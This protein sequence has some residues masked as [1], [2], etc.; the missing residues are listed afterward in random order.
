MNRILKSSI[1]K[2]LGSSGALAKP[3]A[4]GLVVPGSAGAGLGVV[5]SDEIS[6]LKFVEEDCGADSF[7][8]F[9]GKLCACRWQDGVPYVVKRYEIEGFGS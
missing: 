8:I 5:L 4:S 9:E 7:T 3:A 2:A 1:Q 6:V